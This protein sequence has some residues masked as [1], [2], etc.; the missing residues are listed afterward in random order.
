MRYIGSRVR[1][2]EDPR[3]VRGNG[4]YVGDLRFPG[5]LHLGLVRSP[6]AHARIEAIDLSRARALPGVAA[7]YAAADLP[8][9]AHPT[10]PA[11][12]PPQL[13]AHGLYPLAPGRVRYVGEAVAAVLAE[14]PQVLADALDAVAAEYEPLEAVVDPIAAMEDGPLVWEDVPRNVAVD[15]TLGF[16]DVGQAFRLADV[17]VADRFA[18]ARSA[19]AALEPRSVAAIPGGED[20]AR[21]TVWDSTQ[22]PH[23]VRDALA[24]YLGLERNR[25]RVIA[26]DVGG[27]FGPKGRIHAEEYIV[28]ALAL[29]HGRPVSWVASRTEDLL[30]TAQGGGLVIEARLAARAD[31]TILGIEHHIIQDAG[32]YTSGGLAA[33]MNTMRHLLGPYHVPAA[34][35]RLTGVYT[36]TVMTSPLRGGGRQNGIYVV[37]RL[38]DRLSRRLGLDRAEVRRRN[39]IR[40]EEFPHDTGLPAGGGGTVIYD[41][42]SYPAYLDRA[43]ETIGYR[44]FRREQEEARREGRYLGLG[45]AAFTESTGVGAE[46]AHLQVDETGAVSVAVGSPST[47]QGHATTFAQVAAERLGVP[48]DRVTLRS[49]DTAAFGWGTGTFASRMGQYGGNAVSLAAGAVR[50]E[51]LALA[52]DLLEIAPRDLDLV[53]GRVEVK[54]VPGRGIALGD[55]AREAKRRGEPLEASRSFQPTPASTW[56]GGVNAAIVEV[57]VETGQVTILR[58]LVVHDSGRIVNPTIVDG[59]IHGG[60]IHGIGV[61]L[62]EECLYDGEGQLSTAT[63]ADYLLPQIGDVPLVE[64]IHVETPSPFNPEGIK[65]A[66][67]GGTIAAL[68]TVVSAVED[69]LS[70]FGI[71]IRDIPIVREQI[72]LAIAGL[73]SPY[74]YFVDRGRR[75]GVE[76]G[77]A[78]GADR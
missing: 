57:D 16:G 65:G 14:D 32:A 35:L 24:G 64:T 78:G 8:E 3:L 19:G 1:R 49:G 70:P 44:A 38:M 66:G 76:E 51:A 13:R 58:Y 7:A 61:A 43:L 5:M 27:G 56:A 47:G 53:E 31:G 40:P 41:S 39:F 2:S 30:T 4:Q 23:N 21:L 73:R 59:Q 68:P 63:F 55:V 75:N 71:E 45:L 29:R 10:P 36:N 69:A 62:F 74:R 9:L 72:A 42:G 25:V 26:P 37:E 28:A 60:V 52:A 18:C 17:V 15:M 22:A 11:Q 20:G 67:E 48:L 6:H 33:P 77:S 46:G 34:Q 50:E 12:V 54:G